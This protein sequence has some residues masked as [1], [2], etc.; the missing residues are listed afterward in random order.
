MIRLEHINL[1]VKDMEAS[2]QFYQAAFPHWFVRLRGNDSWYGTARQWCHFGD[3]YNFITFNDN[4]DG[5][6]RDLQSN[7]I[8]LTHLG[9]EVVDL[10]ALEIRLK[11]AGFTPSHQGPQHQFRRNIY[12]IDPSGIEVEFVQYT[13]EIPEQRNSL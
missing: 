2:L 10:A 12:F 6:A 3:D 7:A 13:S 9:F 4:G 5:A 11:S 8:G 1:V